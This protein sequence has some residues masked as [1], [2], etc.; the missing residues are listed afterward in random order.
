VQPAPPEP[1][2]RASASSPPEPQPASWQAL[3]FF[4]L[5]VEQK[6]RCTAL[7]SQVRHI[8]DVSSSLRENEMLLGRAQEL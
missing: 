3:L 7:L 2:G 6:K 4:D 1:Q 8:T 5:S